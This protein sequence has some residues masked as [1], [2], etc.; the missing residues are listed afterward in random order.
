MILP[1]QEFLDA[2]LVGHAGGRGR[3]GVGAPGVLGGL[4]GRRREAAVTARRRLGRVCH[5]PA[6]QFYP[7]SSHHSPWQHRPS[8]A[9]V[10]EEANMAPRLSLCLRFLAEQHQHVTTFRQHSFDPNTKHG[11][12]IYARRVFGGEPVL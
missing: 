4:I 3:R 8:G 2:L 11:A 10:A 9:I 5:S 12:T 1:F 7:P 6:S